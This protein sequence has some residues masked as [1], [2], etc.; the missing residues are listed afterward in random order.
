MSKYET[1]TGVEPEKLNVT[2]PCRS[3]EL[4]IEHIIHPDSAALKTTNSS[5]FKLR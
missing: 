2:R 1:I 3:M 5:Q 4:E